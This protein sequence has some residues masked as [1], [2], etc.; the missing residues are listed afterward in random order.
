RLPCAATVSP[1]ACRRL[2]QGS[3][4]PLVTVLAIV[5]AIAAAAYLVA[6]NRAARHVS[7]TIKQHSRNHYHG[8]W[9]TL[10]A[11]VPAIL[12]LVVWTIG[13]SVYL[14]QRIAGQLSAHAG[15]AT[16]AG[17]S[18]QLSLVKSLAAGIRLL[19]DN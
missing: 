13:T 3:Y 7:G 2:S 4:M 9:A 1:A 10:L 14:E 17:Q 16:I 18:L 15:A 12:F 8:W 19:Q 5:L 11:A 6:R